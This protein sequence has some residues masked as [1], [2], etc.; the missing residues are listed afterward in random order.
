M[1]L[2]HPEYVPLEEVPFYPC[3]KCLEK[4]EEETTT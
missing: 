1:A 2:D 4:L 3:Q